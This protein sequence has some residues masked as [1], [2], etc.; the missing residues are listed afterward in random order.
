MFESLQMIVNQS[1]KNKISLKAEIDNKDSLYLIKNLYGDRQRYMQIL[2]NFL[3]NAIKFT[4]SGGTITVKVNVI[5][6]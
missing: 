1:N 5:D 3:S 4:N 2:M 6:Q